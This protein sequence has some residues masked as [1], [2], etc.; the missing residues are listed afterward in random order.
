MRYDYDYN[1]IVIMIMNIF[2][3]MFMRYDN[4]NDNY[5]YVRAFTICYRRLEVFPMAAR[6]EIPTIYHCS[7]IRPTDLRRVFFHNLLPPPIY[8]N[9][10]NKLIK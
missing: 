6:C 9:I 3:F 1:M 5:V 10:R 2:I 8:V 4:D 7:H